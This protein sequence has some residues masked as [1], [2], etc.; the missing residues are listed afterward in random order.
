MTGVEASNAEVDVV[1][2]EEGVV[3]EV[4]EAPA[5]NMVVEKVGTDAEVVR[6]EATV[7]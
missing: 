3:E 2:V 6:K 7:V 1:E 5:E 4:E